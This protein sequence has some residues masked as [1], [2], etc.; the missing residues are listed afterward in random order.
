[1]H[2]CRMIKYSSPAVR[3]NDI[4]A[5]E[6]NINSGR[7]ILGARTRISQRNLFIDTNMYVPCVQKYRT[8][9]ST[10]NSAAERLQRE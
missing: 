5:C 3:P 6:I 8:L 4:L 1:M 2:T 9:F 10:I 7:A